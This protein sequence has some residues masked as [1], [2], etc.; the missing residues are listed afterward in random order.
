M[1]IE[2][3]PAAFAVYWDI[4]T[5]AASLILSIVV[6]MLVMIPTMIVSKGAKSLMIEVIA[7]LFTMALLVAI[8]WL[9]AWLMIVAIM[10]VAYLWAKMNTDML[11]GK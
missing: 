7:G 11:L 2:D 9:P 8:G 4:S 5:D 6:F 1:Q 3:I 10:I